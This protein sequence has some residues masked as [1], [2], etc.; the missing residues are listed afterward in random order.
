MR[1]LLIQ[2]HLINHPFQLT[3]QTNPYF[4]DERLSLIGITFKEELLT[5]IVAKVVNHQFRKGGIDLS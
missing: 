3:I 1:S 2:A 4:F 5:E